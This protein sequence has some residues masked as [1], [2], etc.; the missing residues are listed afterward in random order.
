MQIRCFLLHGFLRTCGMVS[1]GPC[2]NAMW[3]KKNY[4]AICSKW[5]VTLT[6]E[7]YKKDVSYLPSGNVFVAFGGVL[8]APRIGWYVIVDVRVASPSA[9]PASSQSQW[10]VGIELRRA[11]DV[12]RHRCLK[13]LY[14]TIV[15]L[16]LWVN[17]FTPASRGLLL[18]QIL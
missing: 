18:Q 15:P 16:W 9:K 8:V 10:R 3:Q 5:N 17:Y 4:I 11:D 13:G 2:R 6:K 7:V 12:M 14:F 1:S